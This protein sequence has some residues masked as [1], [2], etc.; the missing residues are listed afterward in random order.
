[1]PRQFLRAAT[2]VAPKKAVGAVAWAIALG[3]SSCTAPS[4]SDTTGANAN[5]T[6]EDTLQVVTTFL[7][8]TQFTTAVAGDRAEVVQLLPINVGPHDYQAKPGDVR[9]IAQADVLIKNG[10]EA[11]F[12]LDSMIEN[13]G[14]ADLEIVD[15]SEGIET[16]VSASDHNHAHDDHGH[17]DDEAHKDDDHEDHEEDHD[18]DH[19]EDHDEDHD[20]ASESAD[21]HVWLDPKRAIEQ[22]ENIRDGLIAADPEGEAEYVAN[23]ETFI[24]EL[25][26]L[27]TDIS[28][29]LAPFEGKT[30]IVFH[31]FAAYFADS[32]G[33]Q[34][35]ALV[36]VPEENPSPQD[37]KRVVEIAQAEGLKSL[38]AEPQV[39]QTSFDTLSDD[40]GVDISA[41]NAMEAG[42]TEAIESDYYLETMR[43][44]AQ[45]IAAGFGA[46]D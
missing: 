4:A 27:D 11:E 7:P 29:M 6:A 45:N 5:P 18:D 40:L 9:A 26:A 31:D 32:Y 10:L 44:N 41:F 35:E 23:A 2:H 43:Q 12:F 15:S 38:L 14:N 21:P 16:L 1:M 46:S 33:L 34:F 30:F 13:A 19:G 37:V 42:S 39:E 24:A 17:D 28:T 20:K 3:L 8:M 25:T 36:G 22:V